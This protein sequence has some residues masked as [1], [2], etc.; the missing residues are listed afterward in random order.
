MRVPPGNHRPE[1]GDE[2]VVREDAFVAASSSPK[3]EKSVTIGAI[4]FRK[5]LS[6]VSS[7]QSFARGP[8]TTRPVLAPRPRSASSQHRVHV[9]P[10]RRVAPASLGS[11][12]SLFVPV[13]SSSVCSAAKR[14]TPKELEDAHFKPRTSGRRRGGLSRSNPRRPRAAPTRTDYAQ[15][16]ERCP[17]AADI[18]VDENPG[19]G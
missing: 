11:A 18:E 19:G 13:A 17:A 5:S 7:K 14:L 8:C 6:A 9:Q 4:P 3:M 10:A 1:F 12:T 15:V 2:E 16:H